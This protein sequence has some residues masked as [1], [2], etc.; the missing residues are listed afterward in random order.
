MKMF[1]VFAAIQLFGWCGAHA[2]L[3]VAVEE[4]LEVMQSNAAVGDPSAQF[5]LALS[6]EAGHGVP[7]D[8]ARAL[9]WYRKAAAAG[10]SQAQFNLGMLLINGTDI[11]RDEKEAARWF[12]AAAQNGVF[13]AQKMM[14][15]ICS[16]GRGME[17][18]PAKALA[19]DI[20]ARRTLELR[21]G[22]AAGL[23]PKPGV[24]R[25]DG[26]AEV[27]GKGGKKEWI[28]ADGSRET[29]DEAGVRH[30][31]HRDGRK[32][33]VQP[34]GAWETRY[35]NG[36]TEQVTAQGRKTLRDSHGTLEITEPDGTRSEE[37]D[38]TDTSGTKVRIR[39]TF[40]PDGKKVSHRVVTGNSTYEERADGTRVLET[41]LKRDDGVEL[42]LSEEVA[43]DGKVGKG[44]LRRAD[45]GVGPKASEIWAIQ[46]TLHLAGAIMVVVN[47]K[48]SEAG[49]Y[50]QEEMSRGPE[51]RPPA[52]TIAAGTPMETHTVKL[53]PPMT[54]KP[55]TFTIAEPVRTLSRG[56]TTDSEDPTAFAPKPDIS[57]M[58]REL[59]QI[60]SE[61]RN[62][63]GATDADYQRAQATAAAYLI[64]LSI[65]PQKAVSA[66]AW[67]R[68]KIISQTT[69]HEAPLLPILDDRSKVVPFGPH[70]VEL[71]KRS[72]WKHA[73]TEHFIVHYL[74][75]AEARLTMQYIEGVH[76][77][78]T[79]LMNLDPQRGPAK[80]H[81]F[82]FPE[83]EWQRYL[84]TQG[85]S[86]QLAGFACKT[87]LLLGAA[88]NR[89]DRTESIKV[90]CHE[91]TH[92]LVA[93]FYPGCKPPLWMN[94]GLAEYIALRTMRAKGV[95][96]TAKTREDAQTRLLGK[97]DPEM[98][99]ERLFTRLRYGSETSPD[100]LAAFYANSQKCVQVLFEKL[101]VEGFS[102]FFNTLCAG[103]QPDVALATA[104]GKQCDGVAIFKRLVT[105]S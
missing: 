60:E 99:I 66:P 42:I 97:P 53:P 10:F 8:R 43:A 77:V 61:A 98:D 28:L 21:Y 57:P 33:T 16:T 105:G 5:N 51:A 30:R 96:P 14:V 100:R 74:G 26:A 59:E 86:P 20:L 13:A 29:I 94:E 48:Y 55:E 18:S 31:E 70:G 23:P 88:T 83:N 101:P 76:T 41:K 36:L 38:G 2:A 75:E 52:A 27:V 17:K 40:G 50:S 46:R 67:L 34:D 12:F 1:R 84:K 19:W 103:N 93:R 56:S 90:L 9:E 62:F 91:T 79:Q 78:L 81:V 102:K 44:K 85:H 72:P 7:K 92:A 37:G 3:D 4:P 25:A 69:L 35:P 73:E 87:E 71:I 80:S 63:A 64:P 47:E 6:Y 39:D 82:V 89:A 24:L 104:F 11:P 54:V 45:N 32:T 49:F 58:L 95:F 68:E 22:V 15:K 65:S